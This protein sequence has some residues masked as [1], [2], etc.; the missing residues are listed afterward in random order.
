[1]SSTPS[2]D[3]YK[4]STSGCANESLRSVNA[5]RFADRSVVLFA[6]GKVIAR[7]SGLEGFLTGTFQ[8][9]GGSLEMT[10]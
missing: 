6:R 7:L 1:L 9:A 5:W 3:L 2:L 8:G 10:R 4:A